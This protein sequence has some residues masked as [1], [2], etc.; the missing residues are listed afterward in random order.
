[1]ACT[2]PSPQFV[3]KPRDQIIRL[4]ILKVLILDIFH[5]KGYLITTSYK[6]SNNGE[7]IVTVESN[8]NLILLATVPSQLGKYSLEIILT[9]FYL[10]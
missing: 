5:P 2:P 3:K 10:R 8:T 4:N 9:D 1:V 7:D 6:I